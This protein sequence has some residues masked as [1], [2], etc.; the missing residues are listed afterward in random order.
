M[1]RIIEEMRKESAHE[2]SIKIALS[3]LADGMPYEKIAKYT[4][5]SVDEVRSLDG[6]KSA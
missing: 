4:E 5:L 3:M 1:S 2:N 6:K